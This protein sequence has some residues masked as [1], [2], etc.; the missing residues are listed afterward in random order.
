MEVQWGIKSPFDPTVAILMVTCM[1]GVFTV[2]L[3]LW[4]VLLCKQRKLQSL[5]VFWKIQV[6]LKSL[7]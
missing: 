1:K 7:F 4:M 3:Y 2:L 6:S 5:I